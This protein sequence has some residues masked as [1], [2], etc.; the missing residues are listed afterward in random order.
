MNGKQEPGTLKIRLKG[1]EKAVEFTFPGYKG[2]VK[3]NDKGITEVPSWLGR[4]MLG[5][6]F[7]GVGYEE[8]VE[9]KEVKVPEPPAGKPQRE[10]KTSG[11]E[12]TPSENDFL[13]GIKN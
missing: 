3:F 10:A 5:P 2:K 8:V 9:V 1:L 7:A 4:R 11:K 12:K 6:E 13:E